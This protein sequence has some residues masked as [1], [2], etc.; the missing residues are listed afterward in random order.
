MKKLLVF[1]I[2]MMLVLPVIAETVETFEWTREGT[3]IDDQQNMLSVMASYDESKPGW[4]VGCM[5]GDNM[6]GSIIQQEGDTLHGNIVPEYEQGEFIVTVSEEGEEGLLLTVPDET[7]YSFVPYEIPEASI[8][9]TINTDGLG[10][11]AYALGG[12]TPEFDEEYPSQS[13]YIGLAE[14]ATYVFAAKADDGW[15]FVTWQ[16]DGVTIS[17]EA[18]ITVDVTESAEYVAVFATSSGYAGEPVTD[19]ES[20]KTIGDVLALPSSGY[21][22]YENVFVWAFELNDTVYRAIADTSKETSDAIFDLEYDDPEYQAKFNALVAP[23]AI[24]RIENLS[25]QIPTQEEMNAVVGKTG[26]YLLNNGWSCSGWNLDEMEFY[27]DHGPFR[28]RMIFA[29]EV[30]NAESFDDYEDLKPLTVV[31]VAYYGIGDA[32]S[33]EEEEE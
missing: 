23:L 22:A 14:P 2:A 26:E 24:K 19:V 6:Y 30:K 9:V 27:M 16:K 10:Q 31:S 12:E 5:L 1:I 20:A 7:T 33:L 17:N 29:G 13:A 28:Y 21:T 18:Q 15:Q 8:T 3:F 32:T 25:E 4:Y 11:I